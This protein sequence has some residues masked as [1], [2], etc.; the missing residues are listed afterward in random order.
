MAAVAAAGD[1]ACSAG[2]LKDKVRIP[3]RLVHKGVK[4]NAEDKK[5]GTK[6][7]SECAQSK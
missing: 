2:E 4:N 6:A 3:D 5:V 7:P 1:G